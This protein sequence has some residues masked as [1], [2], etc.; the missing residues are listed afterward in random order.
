[1]TRRWI[2]AKWAT[3]GCS[4]DADDTNMRRSSDARSGQARADDASIG[5][6]QSMAG[7]VA[8][9]GKGIRGTRRCQSRNTST[10]AG[11]RFR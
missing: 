7:P 1:M 4:L 10:K 9:N 2:E 11:C 3:M 6:N 5:S 8:N